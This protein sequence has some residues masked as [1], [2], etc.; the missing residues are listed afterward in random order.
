MKIATF[1]ILPVLALLF[2]SFSSHAAPAYPSISTIEELNSQL[3]YWGYT[4][5][6]DNTNENGYHPSFYT[7]FAMRSSYP[8]RI[9]I[10]SARGNNTR[11]TVILDQTT[12]YDYLFDLVRRDD[13]YTKLESLR[14][15]KLL[16]D[17][18]AV[19]QKRFFS[20]IV[21]SPVYGIRSFVKQVLKGD[22]KSNEAIY[23]KSLSV[24]STLNPHRVFN[25]NIDLGQ[26]FLKWKQQLIQDSNNKPL[27]YIQ[28]ET[29]FIL[30]LETLL[31]GRMN[32]AK[33]P[34]DVVRQQLAATI[35][36]A[37]SAND[38]AFVLS[39][40]E[41]FKAA[42]GTKYDI[43]TLKNDKLVPAIDCTSATKCTLSYPEFTTIYP[44]GTAI[45]TTQD[46]YGNRINDF[47]SPGLWNFYSNGRQEPDRIGE[48]A[49]YGWAPKLYYDNIGNAYHNPGL[50][51][52]GISNMIKEWLGVRSNHDTFWA[53]KRG[54]VSHGCSRLAAGHIWEM[55]HI[56]PVQASKIYQTNVHINLPTDFDIFDIDGDGT[57]E[58]MGVEYMIS[59]SLRDNNYDNREAD[60]LESVNPS[61]KRSYYSK[62]YGAKNVFIVDENNKFIFTNP[63]YSIPNYS[64]FTKRRVT[65]RVTINGNVPL[66]EQTYERDKIQMYKPKPSNFAIRALGR[67]RGCA[68]TTNKVDCGEVA[69]DAE[70]KKYYGL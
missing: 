34:S 10:R 23:A 35:N 4:W 50:K 68:P 44:T 55:R 6:P 64:D 69:S 54:A 46:Q 47:P 63:T 29:N 26:T 53:V 43:L 3:P 19:P 18:K 30:T 41:L 51:F 65:T 9:H 67:I 12:L 52:S 33:K 25:L 38:D 60:G 40:V 2:S 66:Y 21:N 8:E 7:G 36:T 57:Q 37:L 45:E 1:K 13:V 49:Y 59:Y 14:S 17:T 42:T 11:M 27:E 56:L 28:N 15:F 61:T 22:I 62:L 20:E 31:P 58:V 48:D 16:P 5:E 39:A 70:L 24:L 32:L